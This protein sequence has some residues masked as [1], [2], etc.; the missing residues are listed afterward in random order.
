MPCPT[1]RNRTGGLTRRS[2]LGALSLLLGSSL[3]GC[4]SLRILLGS[5]PEKF[6]D[7]QE[8]KKRFLTAFVCTVIPGAPC[9]TPDLTR[10]YSDDFYPFHE[11][12]G[13]FLSDLGKTTGDMFGHEN[14]DRLGLE[15]RTLVIEKGLGQGGAAGKLYT[16]AVFMAQYSF[17]AGIY[18][19]TGGCP[20]IQF[21]GANDGYRP[22]TMAH[23]E[24]LS[25]LAPEQTAD[26]N[27]V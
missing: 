25:H 15:D 8:L 3:A 18:D 13:Y 6:D 26:G 20:L 9:S 24:I 5:Y 14:F 22:T 27:P 16:G 2:F 4:S 10:V 19:D 7:D 11:Y 21:P 12:C 23:A 1:E 17:Y